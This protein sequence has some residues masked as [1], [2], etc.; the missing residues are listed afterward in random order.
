MGVSHPLTLDGLFAYTLYLVFKE[1][2]TAP[3]ARPPPT[4]LHPRTRSVFRGTFQ[5]YYRSPS[6]ST[7]PVS[8]TSGESGPWLGCSPAS[9]ARLS[10]TIDALRAGRPSG[11]PSNLTIAFPACQPVAPLGTFGDK[12][13]CSGCAG[14]NRSCARDGLVILRIHFRDVNPAQSAGG[15]SLSCLCARRRADPR[16]PAP[17]S[18]IPS[19]PSHAA[20]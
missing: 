6:P 13:I 17:R 7:L 2:D 16:S 18:A 8:A 3:F 12:K 19:H 10:R 5:G 14:A 11:E 4:G 20:R 1:P 9:R 15:N